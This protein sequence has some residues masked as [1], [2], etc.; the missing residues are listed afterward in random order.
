M[1]IIDPA[2]WTD[3]H[4]AR[5]FHVPAAWLRAEADANRLP[6]VRA[7]DIYLFDPAAVEAALLKRA[8]KLP[9]HGGKGGTP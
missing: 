7:G 8:R 6:H 1:S 3:R 2:L 4:L 5:V 9:G